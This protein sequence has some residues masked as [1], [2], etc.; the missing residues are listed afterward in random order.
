MCM[1]CGR[2]GDVGLGE[3]W[4]KGTCSLKWLEQHPAHPG[5]DLPKIDVLRDIMR[6]NIL[7][8]NRWSS[9]GRCWCCPSQFISR[10]VER[11]PRKQLRPKQSFS[12]Q[13]GVPVCRISQDLNMTERVKGEGFLPSCNTVEVSGEA[14]CCFS[15]L[16]LFGVG[17][18]CLGL[19]SVL[20]QTFCSLDYCDTV[21][22][23]MI[24][25]N[26]TCC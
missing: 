12:Y 13:P 10:K 23:S 2:G 16:P 4:Y 24:I 3:S 7:K 6:Q 19:E 17:H 26:N 25:F 9:P 22:F 8:A 14:Q 18:E 11:G 21:I 5:P 15:L 20:S 1:H